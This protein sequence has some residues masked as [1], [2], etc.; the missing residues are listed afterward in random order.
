MLKLHYIDRRETKLCK[1]EIE[2]R[3]KDIILEDTFYFFVGDKKLQYA[4]FRENMYSFLCITG[5]GDILS[6]RI[7]MTVLE[8][9]EGCVCNLYYS[10][11][12]GIWSMFAFW[13]FWLGSLVYG[14]ASESNFYGIICV[15]VVYFLV[16]WVVKKHI[17]NIC[18]KAVNV[19]ETE[20]GFNKN[21]GI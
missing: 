1:A 4:K 14:Y 20:L 2:E 5:R 10:R 15:I 16:I 7:H 18:K 12:G 19:L 3:L 8:K 13:C 11:T 6:P 21:T 9:K 17:L